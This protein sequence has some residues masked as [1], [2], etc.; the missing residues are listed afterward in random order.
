MSGGR[1]PS[2]EVLKQATNPLS[3]KQPVCSRLFRPEGFEV[4]IFVIEQKS[5]ISR[6]FFHS[7]IPESLPKVLVEF[8]TSV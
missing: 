2:P 6:E 4:S 3:V 1:G 8:S 7:S 5:K